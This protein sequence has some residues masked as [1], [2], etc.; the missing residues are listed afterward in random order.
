MSKRAHQS[1][2]EWSAGYRSG[3]NGDPKPS[4]EKG[5]AFFGGWIAGKA[6][7]EEQHA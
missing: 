4:D 3:L 1:Q 2:A 6:D 7:R 5:R